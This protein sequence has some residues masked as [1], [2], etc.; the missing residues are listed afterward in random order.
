M[1]LK[2][3]KICSAELNNHNIALRTIHQVLKTVLVY[4]HLTTGWRIQHSL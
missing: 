3:D 4:Y 1:N 2:S